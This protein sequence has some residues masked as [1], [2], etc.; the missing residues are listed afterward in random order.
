MKKV[1]FNGYIKKFNEQ[2]KEYIPPKN[3]WTPVDEATYG[4]KNIYNVPTEKA[5]KLQ[6][7]AIKYQFKNHY[8]NN[9]VYHKFCKEKNF[10][11]DKLKNFEDLEKIPMLPSD[12]YKSYPPGKDF[13]RWLASLYSV[14]LPKI[15]IS[16]KNPSYDDVIES[17]N[18]AG[19]KVC[20]SSGTSGRHTFI[21]R[22]KRTYQMAEYLL[23]KSAVTMMYPMW[24]YDM[25]GYLLMPNPF[26]TYIFAGR[27]AEIYYDAVK[28]VNAAIDRKINT[29]TIQS[30]MVGR[31]GLKGKLQ[32]FFISWM[33]K[34]MVKD[35]VSWLENHEK[36]KNH[37]IAMVG[38]P[39][40]LYMVMKHL[41]ENG[42]SF[43]FGGRGAV[44]T[45]GGWKIHEDKRMPVSKFREMVKEILGIK[46]KH[47]LDLYGMVEG[48][49]WMI[50]C[51]EGHYLHIPHSYY[52]PMILDEEYNPKGYG[53]WGRFAF[54]DGST[55]SYPGF[56]I[57]GDRARLLKRCP[58]C[59]RPGPV[60]EPEVTRAPGQEMRGCAE[61]VRKMIS[62][63]I[64]D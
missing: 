33:Y 64:G 15:K 38:A 14:D 31:Q 13:A 20:Y 43:D 7:K 57:S 48:N 5:Q 9:E 42:K 29:E 49:G 35:I 19:L 1:S 55:Y 51:P 6:F 60:L 10:T 30:S 11:P 18:E 32:G 3:K 59:D 52:H 47:C 41:R 21:P 2:V 28:D 16:G 46:D 56:I 58:V 50:H 22:D 17:F 53:E 4:P 25:Y 12:F 8:N 27:A 54:L 37:K 44:V 39:W 63:D 40:V 62:R 26:K 34:K 36:N 45:G 23:A 61:E 24:R